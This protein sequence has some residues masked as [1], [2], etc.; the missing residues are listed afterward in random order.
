MSRSPSL[1]E[2]AQKELRGAGTADTVTDFTPEILPARDNMIADLGDKAVAE[3][4]TSP[5]SMIS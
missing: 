4:L 1:T 3:V 5:K 2:A